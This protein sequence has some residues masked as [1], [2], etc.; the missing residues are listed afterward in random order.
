VKRVVPDKQAA[1]A[2]PWS[3]GVDPSVEATYRPGQD[4]GITQGVGQLSCWP[5]T[6]HPVTSGTRCRKAT[7]TAPDGA[8]RAGSVTA[9]PGIPVGRTVTVWVDAS[10]QPT[11]TPLQP[12]QV[13]GHAIG[14][15][16]IAVIAATAA[17]SAPLGLGALARWV[18][19][20]RRL[21]AW[22]AEWQ[23]VGP[24]WTSAR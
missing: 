14:A 12:V 11:G 6:P 18:L 3:Q 23:A 4:A 24:S 15:A 16:V 19:F 9:P 13:T 5:P 17:V 10:G 22:D 21:A 1:G 7:W 2:G 8:R 20:R